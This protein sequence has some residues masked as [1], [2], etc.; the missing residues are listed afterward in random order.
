[1]YESLSGAHSTSPSGITRRHFRHEGVIPIP[2]A[3]G[4]VRLIRLHDAYETERV[5]IV[6]TKFGAAPKIPAYNDVD[7][8]RTFLRG[9]RE[10][11]HA[12]LTDN[13]RGHTWFVAAA[14]EY[15]LET[16]VGLASEMPAARMHADITLAA[17]PANAG[18]LPVA[19][20]P[21]ST[22]VTGMLGKPTPTSSA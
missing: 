8:N 11:T 4:E 22:F 16:P 14:Y 2:T 20:I 5:E 10:T 12:G 7:D 13:M 17:D 6:G 19:N 21:A 15:L 18:Q 9:Q 3:S 1:M